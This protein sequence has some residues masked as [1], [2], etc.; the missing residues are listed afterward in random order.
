MED[1][2]QDVLKAAPH[3]GERLGTDE[4]SLWAVLG[5]AAIAPWQ[6]LSRMSR[7]PGR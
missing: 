3:G 6:P 2:G 5:Q 4:P 7:L 1:H